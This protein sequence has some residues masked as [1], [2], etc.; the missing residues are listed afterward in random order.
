MTK[1]KHYDNLGTA[2]FVTF[3][4]YKSQKLLTDENIIKIFLEELDKLR[5]EQNIKIL[6]YVI[7]PNHVHLVLWPPNGIQIGAIIGRLK[8]LS[9][10][11]SIEYLKITNPSSLN[12]LKHPQSNSG[13]SFWKY[14]CYDHN[15]RSIDTI[16]E[17]IRYCHKNPVNQNLV[18]RPEK[19]K[20]SSFNWYQGDKNIPIEIDGLENV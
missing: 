18:E 8:A 9:A 3:G 10:R 16:I 14:R 20:W 19:W 12:N 17:K 7:M 13:F 4:C 1:L 6:G 2:R 15:C 5:T 11:R